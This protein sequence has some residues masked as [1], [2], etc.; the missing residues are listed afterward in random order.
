M[1]ISDILLAQLIKFV[2]V[3]R[4]QQGFQVKYA[5]DSNGRLEYFGFANA[6]VA[7]T[8]E[9]WQIIK[10]TYNSD[11]TPATEK[12]TNDRAIWDSKEDFF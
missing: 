9:A 1:N 10:M 3:G 2:L 6:D 5:W 7:T 11:N 12:C 4:G 8:D